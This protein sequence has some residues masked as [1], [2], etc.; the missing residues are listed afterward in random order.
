MPAQYAQPETVPVR[1]GRGIYRRSGL[2]PLRKNAAGTEVIAG[3]NGLRGLAVIFVMLYHWFPND[4]RGGY[5]GVVLFLALSGYLVTSGMLTAFYQKGGLSVWSIYKRRFRRLYPPLIFFLLLINAWIF[6]AQRGLLVHF[7][8]YASSTLLG[9]NN[10]WQIFQSFSYFDQHGNFNVLT[11]MWTLSLEL[12]IYLIW[13][14]LVSVMGFFAKRRLRRHLLV[15]SLLA[16]VLSALDML[17]LFALRR[18]VS[19]VYY[20]TDARFF[21]FA[22]GAALACLMSR[23]QLT[24]LCGQLGRRTVTRVSAVTLAL[25]LAMMLVLPGDTAPVY[26]GL[27]FLF[28]VLAV[29]FMAT[30][31]DRACWVSRLLGGRLIGWFGSRSYALYLW[32]YGIMILFKDALKYSKMGYGRSVLIQLPIVLILAEL[33]HQ[34]TEKRIP[35]LWRRL[36]AGPS[37]RAG[38]RSGRVGLAARLTVLLLTAGLVTVFV[39]SLASEP[40]AADRAELAARLSGQTGHQSGV[41][42]TLGIQTPAAD[43]LNAYDRAAGIEKLRA[44]DSGGDLANIFANAVQAFPDLKLTDDEKIW[45]QQTP[46]SDIG[47]SISESCRAELT[48]IMPKLELDA[49][50][51]RQ[52]EAGLDVLKA[53]KDNQML[54]PTVIFALGTNGVIDADMLSRLGELYS[55]YRIYLVSIV[56]PDADVEKRVNTVLRETA[57]QYDNVFLI[58]WYDFAKT[59]RDLFY[60]D[61]THP[62]ASGAAVYAQYLAKHV[63]ANELAA[64]LNAPAA[65]PGQTAA[66]ASS[67]GSGGASA[68]AEAGS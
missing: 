24:G 48:Y 23:S 22:L 6:A 27:M 56:Q 2:Q 38:R 29:L 37:V 25:L 65:A 12:Q 31:A 41:V 63:A 43:L 42:S 9:Y 49:A 8:G 21:A 36:I 20:G 33:T 60:N 13:P 26:C 62:N 68:A 5:L 35:G 66:A 51:S 67:T 39:V 3:F 1:G 50:V 4:I 61:G 59:Q 40:V 52:A 55:E 16:A 15:F 45:I 28:A 10:W 46:I 30:A 58:D 19:R 11:H 32:Q 14:P 7:G 47:D 57:E 18:D 17:I 64:A 44:S 53:F 54:R 34:L